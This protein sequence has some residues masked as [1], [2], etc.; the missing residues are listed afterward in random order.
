MAMPAQNP[1]TSKQDY[2]AQST[3]VV[4]SFPEHRAD[5]EG[6]VFSTR[7][8]GK[9]PKGRAPGPALRKLKPR[10]DRDGYL[11]VAIVPPT[12]RAVYRQVHRL[13]CAAFHGAP[14]TPRHEAQHRC[15]L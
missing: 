6:N 5:A 14:P 12:G 11:R 4:P 15:Q 2:E 7:W 13:V 3:R 9:L 1:S 10:V 8:K